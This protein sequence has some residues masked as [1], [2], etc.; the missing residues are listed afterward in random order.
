MIRVLLLPAFLLLTAAFIPS[1][2]DLGTA[3]AACRAGEAGPALM[4]EVVGL[5]DH[6]GRLKI[7]VYPGTE[8]DFLADDNKL[9][10]AGKLFR[11][12][13]VPVPPEHDP[14]ICVRLPAPGRVAVSVLHDRDSNH[15]F[16]WQHDGAGF[17]NNPHLGYS[18]PRAETVSF[19]A[20]PRVTPVR[21]V[22]NYR[23]GLLS[24]GPIEPRR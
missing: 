16:N 3:E 22:M 19:Y 21:V 7:E 11:R 15:R 5:K 23:V 6:T 14:H 20:G 4:I 17:S 9:V 1:S 8:E 18:K 24:F 13:D 2:P 12:I 10:M